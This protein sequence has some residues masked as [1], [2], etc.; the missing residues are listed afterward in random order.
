MS[1]NSVNNIGAEDTIISLVDN[2][3]K[4][5]E[6]QITPAIIAKFVNLCRVQNR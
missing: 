5:L 2:N 6:I 3:K 1:T 4:L